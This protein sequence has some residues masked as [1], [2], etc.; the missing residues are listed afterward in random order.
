MF[1]E[2]MNEIGVKASKQ[3]EQLTEPPRK[4]KRKEIPHFEG[5]ERDAIHQ[6]DTM[7]LP[8]DNGYRYLLCVID[9]GTRHCD[10]EPLKEHTAEAVVDA[11]TKI[12]DRKNVSFPKYMMQ[13]D[14]GTEFQGAVK[15][16]FKDE[17]VGMRIAKVGRHRQ[18][19]LV[20]RMNYVIAKAVNT[21][22]TNKELE[23]GEVNTE[24]KKYIPKIITVLNRKTKPEK[25][26]TD[27]DPFI[28]S[29]KRVDLLPEGT[30][31]RVIME[32]PRETVGG[33]KMA[34]RGKSGF[35]TGD[36]RW[37]PE[38]TEIK[39]I[40]LRPNQPAMYL[41][42]KYPKVPYTRKQ[43]QVVEEAKEPVK[44]NEEVKQ[45][46]KKKEEPPKKAKKKPEIQP[47]ELPKREH[48][49]PSRFND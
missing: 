49:K 29:K 18:Q 26:P 45:P 48:R 9:V 10:A 22:M 36:L 44:K 14:A 3:T 32:E 5:A 35:G 43:L 30:K 39:Q 21:I 41:T 1:K 47:R 38:I 8:D 31:V 7:H 13:V 17:G 40:L 4:E 34:R 28:E 24:W 12:Y 16:Y 25:K 27:D 46:V 33:K 2:I 15:Q 6:A 11:L 20:E 37:E 42:K 19:A 23:T